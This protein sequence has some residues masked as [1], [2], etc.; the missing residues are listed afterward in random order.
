MAWRAVVK[1]S[2]LRKSRNYV[3]LK[4]DWQPGYPYSIISL[5]Q[6]EEEKKR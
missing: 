1:L 5:V 3:G 6:K 4:G 2:L